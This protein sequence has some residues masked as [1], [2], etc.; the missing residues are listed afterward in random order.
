[1]KSNQPFSSVPVV[2]TYFEAPEKDDP[3]YQ[4]K[5]DRRKATYGSKDN[6]KHFNQ[7]THTALADFI[8]SGMEAL[9]L[10]RSKLEFAVKYEEAKYATPAMIKLGVMCKERMEIQIGDSKVVKEAGDY[11]RA[12]PSQRFS[13]DMIGDIA[14]DA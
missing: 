9:G 8:L 2:I 6:P 13:K 3:D 11:I 1:M 10:E 12:M 7:E 14:K 4:D 5:V